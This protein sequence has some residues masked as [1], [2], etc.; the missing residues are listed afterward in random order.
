MSPSMNHP[1]HEVVFRARVV[2]EVRAKLCALSVGGS[3]C[4]AC[5]SS[6]SFGPLVGPGGDTMVSKW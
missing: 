2:R 4:N 3:P 1:S 5:I 6:S